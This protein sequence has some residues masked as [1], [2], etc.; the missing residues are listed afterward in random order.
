MIMAN[1]IRRKYS[2]VFKKRVVLATLKQD[3][4]IAELCQQFGIYESQI[5][6]WKS[7]A[8]TC[9]EESFQK[10]SGKGKGREY[11]QEIA[12]LHQKIGKLTVE[13]DFLEGAWSQCQGKRR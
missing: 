4:T 12:R 3:K 1:K 2:S 13:Q 5:Y 9:L 8:L 10:G 11:E 7:Q 6:A